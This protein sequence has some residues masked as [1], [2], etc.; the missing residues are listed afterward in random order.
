MVGK[1]WFCIP[2]S[3]QTPSKTTGKPFR[4]LK[5][6]SVT[7]FPSDRILVVL[8][9]NRFNSRTEAALREFI[10]WPSADYTIMHKAKK[11]N[12]GEWSNGVVPPFYFP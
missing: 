10:L 11:T 1:H 3:S 2:Q 9:L 8:P 7:S 4:F 12:P 5:Q 6:A